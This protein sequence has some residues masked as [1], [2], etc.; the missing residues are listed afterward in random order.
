MFVYVHVVNVCMHVIWC[1]CLCVYVCF[2]HIYYSMH[3]VDVDMCMWC[4]MCL[5]ACSVV[6]ML[7]YVCMCVLWYVR[8]GVY[9]CACS[10]M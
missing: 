2:V 10:G 1:V 3:V 7:W 5:C 6:C 9:I 4:G 8:C